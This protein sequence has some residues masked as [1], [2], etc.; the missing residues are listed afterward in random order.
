MSDTD[1]SRET[2]RGKLLDSW[3]SDDEVKAFNL[4]WDARPVV[5]S[6]A[7][8]FSDRSNVDA[9]NQDVTPT[10]S[11]L[12]PAMELAKKLGERLDATIAERDELKVEV[13]ARPKHDQ[14]P[15]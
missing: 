5:A 7:A 6:A 13:D 12:T 9:W 10:A 11:T 2:A 4:G 1:T 15:F 3:A 8:G 14:F